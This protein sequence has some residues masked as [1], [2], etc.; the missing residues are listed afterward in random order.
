MSSAGTTPLRMHPGRINRLLVAAVLL[1]IG[2]LVG[3][4]VVTYLAYQEA[5]TQ[6]AL[7]R[8]GELAF[9]AANRLEVELAKL[10]EPLEALARTEG[11][12]QGRFA[13]QRQALEDSR[14]R[15]AVYDGGVVVI[16]SRGTVLGTEP[17]RP[18]IHGRDWSNRP[19]FN[20]LLS[21]PSVYFSDVVEDGPEG[22][23]V[24]VIGVP[25]VGSRG[26]FVGALAGMFVLGETNVSPL[27]ASVVR[28]RLA[29]SGSTYLLDGG[30]RLL[31]ASEASPVGETL[32]DVGLSG[33]LAAGTDAVRLRD[34]QGRD[35]VAASAPVPGTRWTLLL[36]DDWEVLTAST[37][38]YARTLTGLVGAGMLLPTLALVILW[39]QRSVQAR[40]GEQADQELRLSQMMQSALLPRLTPALPGWMVAAYHQSAG[41][42]SRTLYDLFITPEG[43]LMLM[44]GEMDPAGAAA[45]TAMAVV[46]SALRSAAR[47]GLSPAEALRQANA[48]LYPELPQQACFACVYAILDPL[49]GRLD[50]ASAG[51]SAPSVLGH[52]DSEPR[53]ATPPLG[54]DLDARY[55]GE[56][57]EIP[58][59][60]QLVI[61]GPGLSAINTAR[62]ESF[63]VEGAHELLRQLP[64]DCD[65]PSEL[66]ATGLREVLGYPSRLELDLTLL[67]LRRRLPS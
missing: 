1:T 47:V 17:W 55:D 57:V 28:L 32:G 16:D 44:I 56:V 7:E 21:S 40:Q 4:A 25:I 60:G 48:T 63:S 10:A 11:M 39:R 24:V 49:T 42:L 9:F 46:R 52:T 58:P 35:R 54:R 22:A 18:E 51:L 29:Q 6:L 23:P 53:A 43:R 61:G 2:V 50:F 67:A 8:T 5:T 3:A 37:Q 66:L 20:Q 38:R 14:H 13:D 27:Y 62:G 15:L 26:E 19:F 65:D 34:A 64:E 36:V 31:Y 33:A 41:G 12:S 30:G 59:G 45:T